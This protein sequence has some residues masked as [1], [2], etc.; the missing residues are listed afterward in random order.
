MLRL[1]ITY[2]MAIILATMSFGP[3]LAG[4]ITGMI[5]F[6]N[7]QSQRER[8]DVSRRL[9]ASCSNYLS[10]KDNGGLQ[11]ACRVALL[12]SP[13]LKSMQ[14]VRHDGMV[15]FSS[16][17][18]SRHWILSPDSPSTFNQIRIPLNRG[19][20]T[21]AELEI[22]FE[23][24]SQILSPGMVKW[25]LMLLFG[26]ALNFGSFSFFLTRALSVLDPKSAVK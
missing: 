11:K 22:A 20:M 10:A 8:Q 13:E 12:E 26:F 23:P 4:G 6:E 16:P 19:D 15:L 21:W 5:P 24:I 9:A 17:D 3:M 25:I 14:V 1:K 2:K 18:H 7:N